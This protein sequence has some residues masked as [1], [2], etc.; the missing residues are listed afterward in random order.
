L[1]VLDSLRQLKHKI[2]WEDFIN[3]DQWEFIEAQ[4]TMSEEERKKG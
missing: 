4:V 1:I 3:I 2:L